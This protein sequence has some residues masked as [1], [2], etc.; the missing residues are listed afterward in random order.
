LK[1]EQLAM[2]ANLFGG[3]HM[4]QPKRSSGDMYEIRLEGLTRWVHKA[5]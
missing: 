3:E 2:M 5:A 1:S 4:K